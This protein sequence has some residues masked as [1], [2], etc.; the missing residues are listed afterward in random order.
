MSWLYGAVLAGAA[1][2]LTACGGG[3]NSTSSGLSVVSTRQGVTPF[4][5]FV[6]LRGDGLDRV[7]A[8]RYTI[9][10]KTGSASRPVTAEYTIDALKRKGYFSDG[11]GSL[12]LP[13]FGLYAGHANRANI[14]LRHADE[15]TRSISVDIVTAAYADPNEILDRPTI[16]R[17][18]SAGDALGFDFVYMKSSLGSPVVIDT[19]GEIRWLGVSMTNSSSSIFQDNGFIVGDQESL[20]LQRLD[21]D[22]SISRSAVD[23]SELT[24][25]HHNID[26][27]K[28]GLLAEFDAIVGGVP[29]TE[30]TLAEISTSGNVIKSW[31]FADLLSD[32]MRSQGDDPSLFIRPEADWFHMNAA[33]YDPR[34]DSIIVSS[35]ENFLVKVDYQSGNILWIL[36]DPTKYWYSFPSLRAKALTLEPGGLYPI[37]QHATSITSDGLLMIFNNGAPSLNQPESAPVGET[38]TYSAVSAYAIDQESRTAREAWRFDYGQSILSNYCSSAYEAADKSMLVNYSLAGAGTTV[39]VVGLNPERN[40]VFDLAYQTRGCDTSWNAKPIAFDNLFISE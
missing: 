34:D 14:L 5:S 39:R 2:L 24:N 15:T 3:G 27:G 26:P 1:L 16:I 30:S 20:T 19:D 17:K 18:R 36:G 37:G 11:G 38:R 23:S 12:I 25:F 31:D 6:E 32:Y 7:A 22:G 35:R 4:I 13:V 21:L 9:A 40:V 8:A 10:P 29:K 33:T 28:Q